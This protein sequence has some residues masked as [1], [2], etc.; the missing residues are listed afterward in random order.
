MCYHKSVYALLNHRVHDVID[1]IVDPIAHPGPAEAVLP[2]E[3]ANSIPLG[4][5]I[6]WS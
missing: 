1:E 2:P 4:G 6:E 3:E 5:L